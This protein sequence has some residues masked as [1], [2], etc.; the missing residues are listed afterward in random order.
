MSNDG[1][2]M[3]ASAMAGLERQL[4][5]AA[6]NLANARTPG[7]QARTSSTKSFARELAHSEAA[8]DQKLVVTDE[9]IAF[10][11]G[12]IV[13]D[14][15]NALA[16]A[17][18]G[19]GFFEVD[20]PEGPAYTRN[21]DF[22]LGADGALTTR[23]G[24]AVMGQSGPIRATSGLGEITIGADGVV[25]Q[26]DAEVGRLRLFDFGDKTRLE[27]VSDTLYRAGPGAAPSAIESPSLRPQA[28]EYA[29]ESA[30]T[31]LVDLIKIHRQFDAA[32]RVLQSISDSY[33]QRIRT[34]S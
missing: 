32:Q 29:D 30:V 34:S 15:G 11:R 18:D 31:A 1:I 26:G 9:A 3:A 19:E 14:Q 16:V 21:G 13:Q 5:L 6:A 23:A 33:Q 4:D 20:T 8:Q 7:F 22:T 28:L 25:K 10:Q 12:V 17:I 2:T 27:P 24:Y